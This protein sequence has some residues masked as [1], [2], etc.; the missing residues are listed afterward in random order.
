MRATLPG[1]ILALAASFLVFGCAAKKAPAPMSFSPA[2]F[3]A[4]R[5]APKVNNAVFILDASMTMALEGDGNNFANAKGVLGGINNSIPANL[6]FNTG[7]RSFGHSAKQSPLEV[8]LV[9][10]L[11][12]HN[13]GA[14][15]KGIGSVKVAGGNSPLAAALFAA[16]KALK[17]A[18]GRNA[19]VVVSDGLQMKDAPAAAKQLVADRG[20]N[21]CIHT[22][23]VGGFAEGQ[24]VLQ[25][26]AG[27]S[28]CGS[29]QTAASLANSGAMGTFVEKAFLE[30]KAAPRAPVDG[31]D[32]GDGV[33]NS[34]DKCPNT[35]KGEYVD[36]DG[37]SLKLTLHINFDFDKAEIKPE[38][39]SDLDRAAAFIQKH[40]QVPFI[41]IAGHT[42]H[43]GTPEYNQKLSEDRA[44]AVRDY[45]V[46]NYNIDGKRLLS[47]G[48]GKTRPVADNKTKEGRYQNRRV[49]I[50]CCVLPP[51]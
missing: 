21:L 5:Y 26:V 49:E 6:P 9:N 48:Y 35:P 18:P 32:D 50:I 12:G 11:S 27:A 24:K 38:F 47:Q 2:S 51:E 44:K 39:K 3:D 19:I 34:R 13:R 33:P 37:C 15:Q 10:G 31:D 23:S 36:E 22:I 41:L 46:S 43:T 7:M 25:Q 16:G 4:G 17:G 42:D 45:L 28:S 30:R 8:A 14:L 20:G 40:S 1:V 29:Y